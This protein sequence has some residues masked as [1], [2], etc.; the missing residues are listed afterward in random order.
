MGTHRLKHS[1][2][3]G[4]LSPLMEAR[5]DFKRYNS[6]SSKLSN[7]ICTTQGPTTRRDGFKFIYDLNSLGLDVADPR[8]RE[9]PFIFNELQAYTLVFFIHTDGAPRMVIGDKEGLLV[10]P[11][12][13]AP[14]CP[15]VPYTTAYTG[16]ATYDIP[17]IDIAAASEIEVRHTSAAGIETTLVLA[18]DY[19]IAINVAPVADKITVTGGATTA[20]GTLDFYLKNVANPG[21]IVTLTLPTTWDIVGLDYAQSADELY[22]AQSG[23]PPQTLKR[24]GATC[25]ELVTL[26]FTSQPTDWSATNGW[27]ERVTFH[28]QRV[29]YAANLLRR[30]TVWMSRAGD[31]SSFAVSSPLIDSDAVTFTLDSGTQDKI[32][33]LISGKSLN[34]GTIAN[35]WTVSGATRFALTPTN[36][37]AQRQT[38]NGSEPITPLMVG[39]TTLFIERYGRIINEFVFDYT[40]DSYKTSDVTILS[41]HVTENFS[42]IDWT[43]QQ[44]PSSIIWAVRADG[45]LLGLTYQRQHEVIG[46][47]VHSTSGLSDPGEFKAI[48]SI[49][50][51][52]REDEVWVI[53]KRT[54]QGNPKYYL[55]KK[56]PQFRAFINTPV[57]VIL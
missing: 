52:T 39:I 46:W 9:I 13:V 45:I 56:A 24:H 55:E 37:L 21:D 44:V 11:N 8:V 19:T 2:S 26:A 38:N 28:Q 32:V 7:M 23:F 20:D 49:P 42:I 36:I 17:T 12:P 18:V 34:I 6:G 57:L 27:P 5:A 48:T 1:F 25:W 41:S 51:D 53:V 10:Y 47:H 4:E 29:V 33:W 15:P 31:F 3:A 35:E 30:Q 16:L 14:F 43:Y 54:I 50:G 40:Y 22:I